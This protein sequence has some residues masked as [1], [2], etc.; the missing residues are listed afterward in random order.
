M[1]QKRRTLKDAGR[2]WVEYDL[3]LRSLQEEQT[4]RMLF[5]VDP[6]TRLPSSVTVTSPGMKPPTMQFIFSYPEKG[7][8]DVYALGV[9]RDAKLVDLV[10]PADL[11][12]VIDGIKA[13]AERFGPYFTINVIT[14]AGQPW[15][16]GTPF[17]VWRKGNRHRFDVGIAEPTAIPPDP[18]PLNADKTAWWKE[19]CKRLWYVPGEVC[20]GDTFFWHENRPAGFA[21]ASPSHRL[22]TSVV[23]ETKVEESEGCSVRRPVGTVTRCLS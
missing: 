22:G 8:V 13:S 4:A 16:Q 3:T 2:Q 6:A 20:D 7:P 12:R 23:A 19:R 18:P 17:L 1:K 21:P 15:Y 9:P 10:P 5:R 11:A 14:D